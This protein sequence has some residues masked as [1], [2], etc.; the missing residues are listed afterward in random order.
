MEFGLK[1]IRFFS[2][3]KLFSLK[4]SLCLLSIK[5]IKLF[6]GGGEHTGLYTV[7]SGYR[8]LIDTNVCAPLE[9]NFLKHVWKL[10]C[11]PKVRI[12]LWRTCKAYLRTK[13]M[14]YWKRMAYDTYCP[15]C[16]LPNEDVNHVIRA[17]FYAIAVWGA[18]GYS[19]V[20][21]NNHMDFQEW[22]S[23]LF[24][25]QF[26]ASRN[27]NYYLDSMDSRQ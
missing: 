10:D 9:R 2:L 21:P 26:Q 5:M 18:L 8:L 22:L 4:V 17:C 11:P 19:I 14:L 15:R 12:E 1:L 24:H 6:V 20:G 16:N 13:Q 27:G 25:K 7:R 3:R 23:W